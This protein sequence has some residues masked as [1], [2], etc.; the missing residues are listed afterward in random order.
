M[1]TVI[2]AL[3]L[4]ISPLTLAADYQHALSAGIGWG[5]TEASSDKDIDTDDVQTH[6]DIAYR[7]Q[8][9]PEWGVELGYMEQNVFLTDIITINNQ[10]KDVYS[11]RVAALYALPLSQ[12]NRLVFKLGANQYNL[13]FIDTN[14]DD[15]RHKKDGVGL[16]AGLGW[17]FEFSSGLEMS[18]NY[19]FQT[20]D[21]LDTHTTT[22]NLGYRF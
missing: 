9:N 13:K 11:F 10:L 17:R 8:F 20:M 21:L 22:I 5:V 18:V 12:R 15:Q 14:N 4:L 2:T 1:K 19:A 7:Y 6:Y 3:C 16:L